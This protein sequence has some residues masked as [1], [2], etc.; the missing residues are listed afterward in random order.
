MVVEGLDD[1][2]FVQWMFVGIWV[3]GQFIDK[4][5]DGG[6]EVMFDGEYCKVFLW[7]D[8]INF[9]VNWEWG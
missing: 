8:L 2:I 7:Q 4:G 5:D 6:V 1:D 3:V 9:C